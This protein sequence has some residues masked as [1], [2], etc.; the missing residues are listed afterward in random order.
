VIHYLSEY[1]TEK[2]RENEKRLSGK[3]LVSPAGTGK[4]GDNKGRMRD[5]RIPRPTKTE[6]SAPGLSGI[7]A[8]RVFRRE[9]A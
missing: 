8:R 5:E 1:K 6:G 2:V 3:S 9:S 4:P 7:R